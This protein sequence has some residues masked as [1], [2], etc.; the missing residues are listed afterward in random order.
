MRR[1]ATIASRSLRMAII[2]RESSG[3]GSAD[4]WSVVV[5]IDVGVGVACG[6]AVAGGFEVGSSGVVEMVRDAKAAS[7]SAPPPE[8]PQNFI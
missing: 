1:E 6:N 7:R 5:F 4:V 2:I 3:E 8:A